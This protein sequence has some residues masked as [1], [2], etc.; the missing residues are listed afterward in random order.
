MKIPVSWIHSWG[1]CLKPSSQLVTLVT[2]GKLFQMI[3]HNI[4]AQSPMVMAQ[5]SFKKNSSQIDLIQSGKANANGK[6]LHYIGI[7]I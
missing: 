3:W 6:P 5:I 7:V 4:G 1:H 2:D